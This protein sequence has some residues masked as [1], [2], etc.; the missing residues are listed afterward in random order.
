[1]IINLDHNSTTAIHPEVAQT[2][3]E[4]Y[5]HG[6]GNAS[7]S[8]R[9][10]RRARQVL[11][12]AR[13]GIGSILGAD[14]S[15][16]DA[17]RIILTS[18]GTESNNL[19]LLGLAGPTPGRVLISSVEHPSV[20]EP[21]EQLQRRGF[22]VQQIRVDD[23]G[24]VDET[25]FQQLLTADTLLVSVMLA[26]NE[27][28]VLQPIDRIA[29]HCQRLGVPLHTDAVQAVGKIP[30]HFGA[31]QVTALTLTAHKFHGPRGIGALIVRR[32][33]RVDPLLFGGVQQMGL[34]PGTEPIELAVGLDRALR[35][36]Q[37]DAQTR[38]ARMTALRDRFEQLLRAADM[39]VV[40]NGQG[41]AR[42][43]HT[44]NIAFPGLDCQAVHMALDLAGVACS[45]GSACTSGASEPSAVLRAMRLP[46]QIVESSLRFSLGAFTS[47]DDIDQ[48]AE[49]IIQAVGRLYQGRSPASSH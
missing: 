36:W 20:I 4:C 12:D 49:R 37:R 38:A 32:S 45:I 23:C 46:T 5:L 25:H 15:G 26:N 18:G 31:L 39:G 16:M 44:T 22:D 35:C 33:Q 19:A 30:V 43:P 21:A 47:R 2:M 24:V 11:E 41:A 9:H 48:A 6:Y 10:G 14:L 29:Q 7:S 27:T 40:I 17:D 3:A 1:M 42:L 13:E 8:H 28:G 34:R